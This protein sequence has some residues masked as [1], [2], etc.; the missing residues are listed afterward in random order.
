MKVL[1]TGIKVFRFIGTPGAQGKASGIAVQSPTFEVRGSG[2]RVRDL[3]SL[4]SDLGLR[5]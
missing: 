5:V 4:V 3:E 2:F 1:A